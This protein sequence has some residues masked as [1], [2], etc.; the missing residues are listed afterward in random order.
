MK[1][2]TS[3]ALGLVLLLVLLAP[4]AS[5]GATPPLL[6]FD[7]TGDLF[8]LDDGSSSVLRIDAAGTVSVKVAEEEIVATTGYRAVSFDDCG[9]AFDGT[10]NMYFAVLAKGGPLIGSILKLDSAGNLGVLTTVD[11]ITDVTGHPNDRAKPAGIAFGSDGML[12]VN[13]Q[14]TGSVLQMDPASGAVTLFVTEGV[15]QEIPGVSSVNLVSSIV[16]GDNVIYV[17]SDARPNAIF[18]IAP[19]GTPTLLSGFS[20]YRDLDVFMTRAAN[21]H[22]II[23]DDEKVQ[24]AETIY[25]VTPQGEVTTFLTRSQLEAIAGGAV[26]LEGG[27]AFDGAGNFYVAEENTDSILKFDESLTGVVWVSDAD[28]Q[29]VT[30]IGADLRAGIAFSSQADSDSDGIPDTVECPAGP[31]CPDT[32]GDGIPDLDDHDSDN[33]GVPDADE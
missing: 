22:L 2:R 14:L 33:D 18:A 19:T 28:I 15:F 27:I 23:A 13:E 30:G 16:G 21:G 20:P 32:D 26:D 12:Y 7:Q 8:V 31:P 11:Q 25:R 4:D 10:G 5:I 24:R 17:A 6:P 1:V 29:A 3:V 9:I